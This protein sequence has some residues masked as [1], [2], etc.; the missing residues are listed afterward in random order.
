MYYS[1]KYNTVYICTVKV[2]YCQIQTSKYYEILFI[3]SANLNP[4]SFFWALPCFSPMSN[5]NMNTS[6]KG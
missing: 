4:E 3:L 1:I 5:L 6:N 2:I